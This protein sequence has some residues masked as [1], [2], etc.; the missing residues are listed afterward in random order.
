MRM[1]I[2]NIITIS[3]YIV[4]ISKQKNIKNIQEKENKLKIGIITKLY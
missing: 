1:E 2:S 4:I 3:Y